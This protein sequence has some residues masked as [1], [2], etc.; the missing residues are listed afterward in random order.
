M[1]KHK[2]FSVLI[3]FSCF[4]IVLHV[5]LKFSRLTGLFTNSSNEES[6][7][8]Q[9]GFQVLLSNVMF[10]LFLAVLFREDLFGRI[11][12]N[13]KLKSSRAENLRIKQESGDFY[14]HH[15]GV[16]DKQCFRKLEKEIKYQRSVKTQTEEG[17]QENLEEDQAIQVN[18]SDTE[19]PEES[20]L[21]NTF[22]TYYQAADKILSNISTRTWKKGEQEKL[23]ESNEM[24]NDQDR[25]FVNEKSLEPWYTDTKLK[26]INKP[27][28]NFEICKQTILSKTVDGEEAH[29]MKTSSPT[30]NQIPN[31]RTG[32]VKVTIMINN[33]SISNP[34]NF[35]NKATKYI[36]VHPTVKAPSKLSFVKKPVDECFITTSPPR[37]VKPYYLDTEDASCGAKKPLFMEPIKEE[38]GEVCPSDENEA[39]GL[40]R[41][42]DK[43]NSSDLVVL[44]NEKL[45]SVDSC[46][47][48]SE[49]LQDT[50]GEIDVLQQSVDIVTDTVCPLL[51]VPSHKR[52]F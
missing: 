36:A 42:D 24:A 27:E 20:D 52:N 3:S 41:N 26:D 19:T 18:M 44:L 45:A 49:E 13:G 8:A 46:S 39:S 16:F 23:I 37:R 2:S 11:R 28:A 1:A 7:E 25:S 14:E 10:L 15:E 21:E 40:S 50:S 51:D 12:S 4:M 48:D 5:V 22:P 6:C 9:T 43:A 34:E 33:N 31:E 29:K 47:Y 30:I 32:A 38:P 17:D 35:V